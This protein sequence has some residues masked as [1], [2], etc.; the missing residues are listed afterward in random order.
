LLQQTGVP[1][2]TPAPVRLDPLQLR[3]ASF[4]GLR[5]DADA[6]DVYRIAE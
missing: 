5:E 3:P 1:V 6:A 4:K 2:R